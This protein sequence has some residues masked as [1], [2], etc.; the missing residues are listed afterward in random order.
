LLI[1]LGLN[2]FG[3]LFSG[4]TD[5]AFDRDAGDGRFV[6]LAWSLYNV[7]VLIVAA[8]VCVEIPRAETAPR[9]PPEPARIVLGRRN[10]L[11]W[12]MRLTPE[13]CWIRGGPRLKMGEPL[14]LNI[15][16]VGLVRAAVTRVEPS[17]FALALEP[18]AE[19]RTAILRK[20]HTREGNAG[21]QRTSLRLVVGGAV[22]RGL[23]G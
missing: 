23:R 4:L 15:E 12:I 14:E 19:Q 9:L 10:A 16:T 22:R 2:V 11:G 5:V 6:I 20:L 17:G 7:V 18:T 8:T 1:L 3:M 21:T 13:D